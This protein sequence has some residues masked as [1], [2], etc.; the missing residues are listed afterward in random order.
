MGIN[1]K[2]RFKNPLFWF[3]LICT[4]AVPV[5]AGVGVQW[6]QVTT[7]PMLWEVVLSAISNPVVVVATFVAAW[8]VVTDP[9]T[10]GPS[11]SALAMA[12]EK[13]KE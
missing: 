1:W 13:P 10:A 3:Q 11:D 7:W 4:I 12:Y 9:T 5:L 6:E 8:G 2:V